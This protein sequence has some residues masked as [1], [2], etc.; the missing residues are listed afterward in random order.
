MKLD[1]FLVHFTALFAPCRTHRSSAEHRSRS[2]IRYFRVAAVAC[3]AALIVSIGSLAAFAQQQRQTV[4]GAPSDESAELAKKLQNPVAALI[5]VPFQSNF[6]WGGGP[7]SEGFKYTLNLQPVIPIS[8]TE[9]WNLISR[10]IVPIIHQD[11]VV[12]HSTQSGIGDI[13]QSAFFSPAAPSRR[14]F[15]WGAGPVLLLPTSTEDFLGAQKFGM[16]PTAVVLKQQSGWTYGALANHIVSIGGT[17]STPDVNATFLQPFLSYTTKTY[18]TLGVSSESTYDWQGSK[19]TVPLIATVS[20]LL[21]LGGQPIQ[22]QLGPK[23][24]VEG[25]TGAPDW[26]IRFA[27]FLLFPR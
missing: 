27:V 15:I 24:Y 16:G 14:G 17:R 4:G 11:D 6:E 2:P 5:S 19:W 25:P 7:G 13:I 9:D 1:D 21:K 10:T 12:P 26:G 23:L 20:Q 22:F 3:C 18:T 8:L